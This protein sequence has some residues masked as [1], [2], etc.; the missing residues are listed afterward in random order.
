MNFL[1]VARDD[2]GIPLSDHGTESVTNRF[3]AIGTSYQELFFEDDVKE[4]LIHQEGTT[5]AVVILGTSPNSSAATITSNGVTVSN[6]KQVR[7]GSVP[8]WTDT[9]GTAIDL[10]DYTVRQ[11]IAEGSLSGNGKYVRLHFEAQSGQALDID[12]VALVEQDSGADGVGIPVEVTFNGSS[13]FSISAGET[14]VSDE[15]TFEM[16]ADKSYLVVM[17]IGSS[18]QV[19][20]VTSG[21]DGYYKKAASNSYDAATLSGSTA[22]ASATAC[23]VKIGLSD[24]PTT[25]YKAKAPADTI[26][27][28]LVGTR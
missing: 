21:G 28:S 24:K 22:V 27:I 25:L 17:D 12:N 11:V 6:V 19:N 26:D 13:G 5:D 4:Y 1:P 9:L 23:I 16:R 7:A 8:M 15:A 3:A 2:N 14:I 20:H 10:A 18:G